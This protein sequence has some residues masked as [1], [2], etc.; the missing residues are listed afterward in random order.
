MV[1]PADLDSWNP[2]AEN[3]SIKPTQVEILLT[4]LE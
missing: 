1:L 2:V 3:I 4:R